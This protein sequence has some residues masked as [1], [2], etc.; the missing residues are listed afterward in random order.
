MIKLC[1][2]CRTE[3]A[4]D[5][6]FCS[7]CGM[8]LIRAPTGISASSLQDEMPRAGLESSAAHTGH[9]CRKHL[10]LS[11][12][13]SWAICSTIFLTVSVD[14]PQYRSQ[15]MSQMG[16]D[17]VQSGP[18]VPGAPSGPIWP[19]DAAVPGLIPW[20]TV[21]IV[22]RRPA[23]AGLALMAGGLLHLLLLC[24]LGN[25]WVYHTPMCPAIPGLFTLLTMATGAFMAVQRTRAP[26]PE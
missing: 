4:L 26:T 7:E 11:L 8:S 5:A 23:N 15:Y 12:A 19:E 1:L 17:A 2:N 10:A 24:Q 21:F 14:N 3:N 6:T 13:I 9:A 18:R 16:P 20:A 25:L 22:W